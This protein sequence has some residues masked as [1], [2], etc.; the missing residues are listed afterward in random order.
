M[1][2]GLYWILAPVL[3]ICLIAFPLLV[4]AWTPT[5]IVVMIGLEG[6]CLGL[7]IGLYDMSRFQWI[8]RGVCALVFLAYLSY[9]VTMIFTGAFWAGSRSRPSV[10]SAI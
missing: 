10:L 4:P 7:L 1:S 6:F 8:L 5:R 3:V 2:R 9:V